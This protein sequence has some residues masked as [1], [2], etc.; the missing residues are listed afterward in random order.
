MIE[1]LWIDDECKEDSGEY[2]IMGQ[3]FIEQAYDYGIK[4]T[5]MLTY[6]EGI[7]AI[8]KNP[9]KW[10]AVILDIHNARAVTEKPSDDFDEAKDEIV[11][12]HAKN[13]QEEPY[14]FIL[15]GNKQYHTGST[16]RK[17]K[18]CRKAI[19]D[20]NGED[21]K[22]LFEDIVKIQEISKLYTCQKQHCS[23]LTF[24]KENYGENTW[25]SL[26]TLLFDITVNGENKNSDLFNKMRKILEDVMTVLERN[27]Y[28]Y[29]NET[30]EDKSLNN[31]SRYIG[32][33]KSTPIYI[34][35]AFYTLTSITQNGSHN[36]EVEKDVRDSKAP[37]LL[38]SCLYELCNILT[39]TRNYITKVY[40]TH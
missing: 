27:E 18:Y 13:G 14:T 40:N 15:S 29:F 31:F 20:K 22:L 34:R 16:L 7:D 12:L 8:R 36:M 17:P 11:S 10:C 26:L 19:Y 33:E 4:I 25:E 9:L 5:P 21:Y 6:K 37:Y 28:S 24:V 23:L 30:K 32:N 1:V 2:T 38:K 39:W 3:E 35:R